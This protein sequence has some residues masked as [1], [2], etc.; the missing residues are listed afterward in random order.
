MLL[1]VGAV[2][3]RLGV[4]P[5][6]VRS[7]GRRYELVPAGRTPGGHRRYTPDDLRML[8]MM[9]DLVG[10][11]ASPARAARQA[12]ETMSQVRP[13]SAAT[14]APIP[15][16]LGHRRRA[17]GPGGRVLS[18]P[19]GNPQS[20]GLARIA[21]RLDADAAM[22][23]LADLL[24]DRGVLATWDEVLLPVLNALGAQW[25]R[26]GRDVEVE[27]V[28]SEATVEAFRAYRAFLPGPAPN[29]PILLAGACSEQHTL[30]LHAV[31]AGL[32]ERRIPVRMLGGRVPS[33]ALASA[34]RRTGASAVFV[35]RQMQDSNQETDDLAGIVRARPTMT[36]VVGGPGWDGCVIP[37]Q[38]KRA[39]DLSS[40]IEFC[41]AVPA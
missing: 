31:A 3:A 17:G 36:V 40:A 21:S 30:P 37:P 14:S 33:L 16:A 5:G 19:G 13:E 26:T 6:T 29:R 7:W 35:W 12:K 20:R 39:F 23:Q 32:T 22:G 38:V 27:H 24:L 1:S 8:T 9:Q 4:A 2:A 11:G 10:S 18:V 25:A 34:A 28:M 41:A 15:V